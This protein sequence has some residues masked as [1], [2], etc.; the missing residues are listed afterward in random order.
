MG[1]LRGFSGP[2]EHQ[3]AFLGPWELLS[4]TSGQREPQLCSDPSRRMLQ[5]AI[6]SPFPYNNQPSAMET[7]ATSRLFFFL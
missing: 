5:R 2:Q 3:A 1:L 7:W 4:N 6:H